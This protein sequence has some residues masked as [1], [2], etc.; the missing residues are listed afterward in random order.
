MLPLAVGTVVT[1]TIPD[2]LPPSERAL[3]DCEVAGTGVHSKVNSESKSDQV[4]RLA[5]G[6]P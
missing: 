2:D 3:V 4:N 5:L 6:S 1:V